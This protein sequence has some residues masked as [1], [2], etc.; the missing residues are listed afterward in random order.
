MFEE[1]AGKE[2]PLL[3]LRPQVRRE[4]GHLLVGGCAAVDLAQHLAG[5]VTRLALLSEES[6]KFV[7]L[8]IKEG[9][10]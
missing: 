5:T 9:S 4:V 1:P 2:Q 7:G 3:E 6:G 8:K 10:Q